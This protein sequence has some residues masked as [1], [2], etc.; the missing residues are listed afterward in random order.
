MKNVLKI[1]VFSASLILGVSF[2]APHQAH[3]VTF[4]PTNPLD[5]FC[6][7]SC[8]SPR[9]TTVNN[10]VNS[11]NTNSFNNNTAPISGTVNYQQGNEGRATI[12][13]VTPTTPYASVQTTPYT[14]PTPTNSNTNYNY[15]Y[16]S[17]GGTTYVPTPVYN[18]NP[19]T[20]YSQP[21]YYYTQPTYYSQPNYSIPTYYTQPTYYTTPYQYPVYTNTYTQPTYYYNQPITYAQGIQIACAADATT[22]R[23]GV[24][25]TW[26]AEALYNNSAVGFAYSWSGTDGLY[27]YQSSAIM[28]YYSTGVKS[29]IVTV[30][31]PNG[32]TVSKVCTNTVT[33][34]SS[35]TPTKVVKAAPKPVVPATP[36]VVYVPA[37]PQP[38]QMSAATLFSLGNVPWGWVGILI[39]LVLVGII[40]YL[41]YNHKKIS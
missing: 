10:S 31:A 37:P 7:F 12:N 20:Y 32:E 29:A 41:M 18:Y 21:N 16:N 39:I 1:T 2:A 9:P 40:L 30:T 24:P 34:K 11:N 28:T 17:G 13:Q 35:Y 22:A 23:V 38:P 15:N 36:Q 6:L 25:V 19:P 4:N 27:G 33:V 8:S 26:S 3:A 5:P 14:S